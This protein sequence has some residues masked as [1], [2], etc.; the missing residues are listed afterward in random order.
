[1][2][3]RSIDLDPFDLSFEEKVFRGAKRICVIFALAALTLST[4][5]LM[6]VRVVENT[7]EF[8]HDHHTRLADLPQVIRA[9][10]SQIAIAAPQ[11]A[12][13]TVLVPRDGIR[14]GANAGFLR[15][16]YR[17]DQ[18][19]GFTGGRAFRRPSSGR[20]RGCDGAAGGHGKLCKSGR[21]AGGDGLCRA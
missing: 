19:R 17:A 8:I 3:T 9:G 21:G 11:P 18:A 10:I 1:M 4:L 20:N 2:L 16:R 14:D 13:A 5:D 12:S 6:N 7:A 15:A